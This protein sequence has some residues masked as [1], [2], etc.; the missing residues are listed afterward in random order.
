VQ[1]LF[2]AIQKMLYCPDHF[3]LMKGYG[4]RRSGNYFL[5]KLIMAC[6]PVRRHIPQDS[7]Q[8]PVLKRVLRRNGAV[9]LRRN[10]CGKSNVTAGLPR[11]ALV[12]PGQRPD[13]IGTR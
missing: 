6:F 10:I 4:I 12:H 3:F 2:Y 7:S 13:E 5:Q 8:R 11:H 9:T 1:I